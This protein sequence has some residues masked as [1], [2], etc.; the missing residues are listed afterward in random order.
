M[1]M[2]PPSSPLMANL[3]PWPSSPTR[4]AA[5]T[6]QL[7]K[8]T[9]RVGCAFQPIFFSSAPKERPGVSFITANAETPLAPSSPVRANTK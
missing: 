9:C 6:L 5:G 7:S 4:L 3:K 2:R 1:L 8:I